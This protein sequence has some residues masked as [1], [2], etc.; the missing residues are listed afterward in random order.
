MA[1]PIFKVWLMKNKDAWYDLS[2]EEQN[3]L[4]VQNS[5]SF[6]E[7]GA[8]LIMMCNCAWSSEEWQVWGIEKFPDIE[9]VQ[10]HTE[11]LNKINWFRYVDA[12]IILG[13]Q[14]SLE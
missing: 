13:T 11:N 2:A 1:Q 14:I 5:E 7:V 10:K 6:K 8:E 12:K 4:M 9:A 3:K